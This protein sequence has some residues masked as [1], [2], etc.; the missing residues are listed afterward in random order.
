MKTNSRFLFAAAFGL[1]LALTFG[2]SDNKDEGSSCSSGS[3]QANIIYGAAVTYQGETYKTVKIGNQIWFQRNL[4][5]YVEGS[6]C[7]NGSSLSDA[8]TTTCDTYG[9]LYDWAAAM[10]LPASCNSM[11]CSSI[12]AKRQGICPSGWHIPSNADWDKLFRFVD[13]TSDTSSILYY[14]PTA[15]RYLKARNGWNGCGNGEDTFGFA[16]LPNA[17]F[18]K[19]G[20][21]FGCGEW[22]SASET[23]NYAQ[24][25]VM[26]EDGE[27]ATWSS[28]PKAYLHSVRCLKD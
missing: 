11:S 24:S 28:G 19:G 25:R 27:Y 3:T 21:Y 1:A 6:K 5:Y 20:D 9:R 17:G 16:A 26:Y 13:G 18:I 8:N 2:C 4:N 12:S 23:K 15:G 7:V 10:N 14:S 22:W